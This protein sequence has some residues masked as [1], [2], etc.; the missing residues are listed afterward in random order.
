[1]DFWLH[2]VYNLYVPQNPKGRCV[3]LPVVPQKVYFNIPFRHNSLDFCSSI[4]TKERQV[5]VPKL[6]MNRF[7]FCPFDPT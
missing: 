4:V 3:C 2:S 6:C 1:M 5:C 7:S